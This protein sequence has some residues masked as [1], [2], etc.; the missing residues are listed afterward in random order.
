MEMEGSGMN[1]DDEPLPVAWVI[2]RTDTYT[3]VAFPQGMAICCLSC[4]AQ[5]KNAISFNPN[6]VE[7]R[8]CGACHRFLAEPVTI[9]VRHDR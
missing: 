1:W 3:I 2:L 4:L 8:Y 5:G 9:E 6:D 7:E